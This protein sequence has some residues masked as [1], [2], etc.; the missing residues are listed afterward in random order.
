MGFIPAGA[1]RNRE[2]AENGVHIEGTVSRAMQDIM[3]DPQTSGGLMIS[4]AENDA[5]RLLQ[6][7]KESGVEASIIGYVTKQQDYSII[8]K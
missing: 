3:Y 5:N 1:Y 6:E 4:A 2:F 7:L 8:L